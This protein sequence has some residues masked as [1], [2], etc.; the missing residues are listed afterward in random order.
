M[1]ENNRKKTFYLINVAKFFFMMGIVIYHAQGAYKGVFGKFLEPI[2]TYGGC[3]GN[4]FFF[5]VSGFLISCGYKIKIKE[6]KIHMKDF[7]KKRIKKWY[8]P[9]LVTMII[10]ILL[11]IRSNSV[12]A[13]NLYEIFWNLLFMTS[14]WFVDIMPYNGPCWFISQLLLCLLL[15]YLII[16]YGKKYSV[17]LS[18]FMI[19]WGGT[20]LINP[21][22]I[23]FC[24][25]HDGIGFVGFFSGS[26]L[27]EGYVAV[28]QRERCV[29]YSILFFSLFIMA[30]IQRVLQWGNGDYFYII[31]GLLIFIL[32][33]VRI[34]EKIRMPLF[35][36]N[37]KIGNIN[38][39]MLFWHIPILDL[40]I[41]CCGKFTV[42]GEISDGY[43]MIMYLFMVIVWSTFLAF[44]GELFQIFKERI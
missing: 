43:R 36:K 25:S 15:Y 7:V 29:P 19:I 40:F 27:Y 44:L 4:Y 22:N 20:L 12:S 35:L 8:M 24:Y 14:G 13:L 3:V 31:I 39:H 34:E 5:I 1:G 28:K 11:L 2:Y 32:L 23:P 18:I 41:L 30:F 37:K 42:L 6:Q 9:Y 38:M 17:L 21:F 16:R 33:I 26:I 10:E